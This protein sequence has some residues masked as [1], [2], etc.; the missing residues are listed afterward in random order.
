[1]PSG[2]QIEVMLDKKGI[3]GVFVVNARSRCFRRGANLAVSNGW[4]F[5][6]D[7]RL[8]VLRPRRQAMMRLRR[9]SVIATLPL[10]AWAATASAECSWI[11]WEHRVTPSTSGLPAESWSSL[12]ATDPRGPIAR[13]ELKP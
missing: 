6:F 1:M 12:E 4:L 7:E 10:L 5:G 11:F 9:P 3:H 8:Q 13:H 2:L